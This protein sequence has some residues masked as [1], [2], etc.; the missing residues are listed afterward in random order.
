MK[1]DERQR[2][3]TNALAQGATALVGRAK[4]GALVPPRVLGAVLLVALLGGVWYYVATSNRTA[5]SANWASFADIARTGGTTSLEEYAKANTQDVPGRLARLELARLKLGADG[6]G[7]L[8]VR[9]VEQRNKA[10]ASVEAA[11]TELLALADEFR[12]DKT[13]QATCLLEAA[14]AELSLVGIPKTAGG[15]DYR[16]TVGEAAGLLGRAADLLGAATPAGESLTKRAEEL[17]AN[18]A[19]VEEVGTR[20]NNLL[21]PPPSLVPGGPKTPDGLIPSPAPPKVGDGPQ[22]PAGPAGT[23]PSATRTPATPR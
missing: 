23:P 13:M 15:A 10:V 18:K 21:T 8:A 3:E 16:G 11:R 20:L 7:K 2:L 4:S 12:G 19:Q 6:I 17:K 22:A 14:D 1:A 9:D 5:A